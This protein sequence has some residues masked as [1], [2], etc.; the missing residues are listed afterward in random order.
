[1]SLRILLTAAPY[2][3]HVNTLLPLALAA[4][5]AGH[6]VALATGPD[7]APHVTATGVTVWPIG[8]TAA[9][10]GV[11]RSLADFWRTGHDRTVEL[12]PRA[13]AWRPDLVV[14]EELE[15]AGPVAAART[16]SPL[17]VHGLGIAAAGGEGVHDP[18]I[19]RLGE[20]WRVPGLAATFRDAAHVSICP[21]S[22]RPPS[23]GSRQMLSLRPSLAESAGVTGLLPD[24]VAKLPRSRTVHLTL[25]TVFHT[26]RPRVLGTALAGL[27]DLDMNVVVTV[28]PDVDPER[29]GPQPA[30][31][32]VERYVPH[33]W[34]LPYCD[35][36]VSQGGAG[37]LLGALAHGLPQLV[38]PQGAD[39]FGNAEA[40]ERAGA[41]LTLGTHE[42]TSS[43]VGDG[44]RRLLGEAPFREAARSIRAEIE[45][46]PSADQVVAALTGHEVGREVGREVVAGDGR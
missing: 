27:R 8:P 21:P 5:R 16:G 7:L 19:V 29:L 4:R 3:G 30:H 10:T 40:V 15:L 12:L 42:V 18:A 31:V 28:G 17:V 45:A 20:A 32:L 26:R 37:I 25:G 46:M 23:D 22:L 41:A 36:V 2:Y 14:S 24:R 35:V 39:Q 34:L 13:E 38:L 6:E 9:A 33:S 1:M 44:V 11:P 43:N